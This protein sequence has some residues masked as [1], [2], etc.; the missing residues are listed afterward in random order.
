MHHIYL[1]KCIQSQGEDKQSLQFLKVWTSAEFILQ[2]GLEISCLHSLSVEVL[3]LYARK[4]KGKSKGLVE[5]PCSV[6]WVNA[7]V[8]PD[9]SRISAFC[10]V[11]KSH[12]LLTN[13]TEEEIFLSAL[14]LFTPAELSWSLALPTAGRSYDKKRWSPSRISCNNSWISNPFV[15]TYVQIVSGFQSTLGTETS[16]ETWPTVAQQVLYLVVRT[17]LF[18]FCAVGRFYFYLCRVITCMF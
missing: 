5:Q 11:S 14:S 10:H 13:K 1:H 18:T 15:K 9:F 8:S 6:E 3:G 12:H 16:V 17:L 7:K 2:N 4:T